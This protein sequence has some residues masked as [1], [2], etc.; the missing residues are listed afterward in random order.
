M[1]I[2]KKPTLT[3]L[4]GLPGSGKTTNAAEKS[5][6]VHSSDA[7][8][9]ELYGDVNCQDNNADLFS[10]L[11]GRIKQDLLDGKDV[12][13][14]ACSINKKRRTAFLAELKHIPCY[15]KCVVFATTYETCLKNNANRERKVPE[16]V[17]KRMY[18]HWCPPDYSEGFD[19]I[20]IEYNYGDNASRLKY[21]QEYLFAPGCGI[22]VFDQEN[23]H[24]NLTLGEHCRMAEQYIWKHY[25]TEPL[26]QIAALYHDNGKVFTKTRLNMK[27]ED[28]GQCH[29]YQHHCVGAYDF[30]FYADTMGLDEKSAIYISNLIYF[31]M[32]PYTSWRNSEKAM[33]KAVKAM[34]E[35]LFED[36]MKLH[37]ADVAAH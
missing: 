33:R 37:E 16:D 13:Y 32:H 11:H 8:R 7:L 10:I 17:I 2:V 9:Q 4:I 6:V 20:S 18:M 23:S 31:H 22:D 35:K 24:H 5:A 14:D 30:L 1:S 28:D 36:V 27:G 12:I 34:G 19:E 26:L 15:K 29:Y 25:P 21:T 3:L